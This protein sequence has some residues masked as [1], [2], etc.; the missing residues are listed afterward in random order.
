MRRTWMEKVKIKPLSDDAV[1]I[2]ARRAEYQHY[3]GESL[4]RIERGQERAFKRMVANID[5]KEARGEASKLKL[6]K[7]D[8]IAIYEECQKE[9]EDRGIAVVVKIDRFRSD[10]SAAFRA[11]L[12]EMIW[13]QY[14]KK[15]KA[16]LDDG[17]ATINEIRRANA[18]RNPAVALAS[19]F[20]SVKYLRPSDFQPA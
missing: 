20:K 2:D 16:Q 14:E 17:Q 11:M 15:A 8:V 12:G 5:D 13:A 10:E 19:S 1:K 3:R 9:F 4:T 18:S 7:A 6:T